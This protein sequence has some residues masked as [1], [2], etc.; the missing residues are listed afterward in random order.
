MQ[1]VAAKLS[2]FSSHWSSTGVRISCEKLL[3]SKWILSCRPLTGPQFKKKKNKISLLTKVWALS[4]PA[5]TFKFTGPRPIYCPGL[6][7]KVPGLGPLSTTCV[8]C[9]PANLQ[10]SPNRQCPHH[11]TGISPVLSDPSAHTAT[12]FSRTHN[13]PPDT[14]MQL[15]PF[16]TPGLNV[17]LFS[18]SCLP[19]F[20]FY[21]YTFS[22]LKGIKFKHFKNCY[23]ITSQNELPNLSSFW[24]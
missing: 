20:K 23:F 17:H 12:D 8:P 10:P 4:A 24:N 2:S 16:Q 7:H 22:S 14:G 18:F 9:P 3:C 5:S 6:Y 19:I 1:S 13:W 21:S 15:T 11:P